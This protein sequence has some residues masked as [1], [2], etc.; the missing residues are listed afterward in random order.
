MKLVTP[1][2]DAA[3]FSDLSAPEDALRGLIGGASGAPVLVISDDPDFLPMAKTAARS[4]YSESGLE[5]ENLDAQKILT[6]IEQQRPAL[7]INDMRWSAAFLD[8]DST[9]ETWTAIVEYLHD[10]AGIQFLSFYDRSDLVERQMQAIL[11]CHQQFL[12]PSGIYENPFWLPSHLRF[13]AGVDD[14]LSFL[15]GRIVPDYANPTLANPETRSV[16]RGA[17]PSWLAKTPALNVMGRSE[18]RWQIRCLGPLRLYQSGELIDWKTPGGAAQ[19][20]RAL[21]C[22][23]LQSGEKGAQAD[24]I[25]ELLWPDHVTE[26]Q[27][28]ARLHHAI[29]ILRKTL[30]GKAAVLRNGEYYALAAPP[31]SW[32]DITAFEQGCRRGLTLAKEG[33]LEAAIRHYRTAERLYAGDLFEDLPVEYTHNDL[34]DWCRPQ[35]R[36]LREMALKLLRDMSTVLRSL[37][38]TEEALEKCQRALSIDLANETTN[39]EMLHILHAQSRY[40]AMER[41]FEQYLSV[42]EQSAE[43]AQSTAIHKLYKR[44][45]AQT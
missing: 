45:L 42:T 4:T 36:W 33:E 3:F 32:T 40:E 12:S 39:M 41:Q 30:G 31:G 6:L 11:R 10:N 24:R 38:Q 27:K 7:V 23:L 13:G 17:S 14:Q 8:A 22:Y 35:R 2:Q 28:R 19:K 16:A 44:L 29:A 1:L 9:Y 37:D 18:T 15:L 25:S 5:D 20:S 34:E 21:I 26:T 43:A